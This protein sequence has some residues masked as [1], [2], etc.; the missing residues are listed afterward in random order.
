[1]EKRFILKIDGEEV[2]LEVAGG[3]AAFARFHLVGLLVGP[4]EVETHHADRYF[5]CCPIGDEGRQ[6]RR[7]ADLEVLY[8]LISSVI[9]G[10][11]AGRV[12]SLAVAV[13]E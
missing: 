11:R 8:R 6:S 3:D 10:A 2:Y 9:L 12:L 7:K 1:M 4:L 5:G 13:S